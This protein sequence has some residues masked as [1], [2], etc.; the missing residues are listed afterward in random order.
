MITILDDQQAV[1]VIWLSVFL[2]IKKAVQGLFY[3]LGQRG[4]GDISPANIK[5]QLKFM[6]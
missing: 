5:S 2:M 6:S 4:V 1:C 3:C